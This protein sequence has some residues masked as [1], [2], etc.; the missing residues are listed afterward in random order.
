MLWTWWRGWRREHER[1]RLEARG[2]FCFLVDG[3]LRAIDPF[4]AYRAIYHHPQLNLE[5]DLPLVEEAHEPETSRVVAVLC[6]VF[7][8]QRWNEATR[9]GLLDGEL[10]NLLA[11][12]QGYIGAL[13]KN[14]ASGPSSSPST[15]SPS[16]TSP[17]PPDEPENASWDSGP[18]VNTSSSGP[19]CE[20][21][22]G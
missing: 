7:G 9:R 12:F 15:D 20:P 4:A 21:C 3:R 5:R 16:S 1:R 17:A 22:G 18:A 14:T 10:I 19:S 6:E 8:V 13:K 2:L 11:A